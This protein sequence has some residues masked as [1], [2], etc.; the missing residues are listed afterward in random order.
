MTGSTFQLFVTLVI[1]GLILIG[2]EVFVPGGIIGTLGILALLASIV[3][4]FTA[5][6]TAG[7]Y[8]M[9]GLAIIS[10]VI[11]WLWIKFLPRSFLGKKLTLTDD[12]KAF[13]APPAYIETLIDK[14]GVALC[15]L[16]PSGFAQF[17]NRKIDV[18]SEGNYISKGTRV[19]VTAVDG[20]RVIV[21][22]VQQ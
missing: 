1:A 17:E 2:G 20:F 3:V 11:I 4:A 6:A 12:G 5:G 16:R 9:I 15:E 13:K 21:R 7:F 19:R 18:V 22:P 8:A 10:G 14:E